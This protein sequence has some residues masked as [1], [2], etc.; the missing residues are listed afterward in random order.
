[1]I[2]HFLSLKF[3]FAYAIITFRDFSKTDINKKET[4]QIQ[5]QQNF[6]E[7]IFSF[8]YCKP[9]ITTPTFLWKNVKENSLLLRSGFI[10]IQ[11]IQVIP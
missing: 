10:M 6:A 3:K 9:A 8:A 11:V 7:V 1:M 2:L 5:K 4:D